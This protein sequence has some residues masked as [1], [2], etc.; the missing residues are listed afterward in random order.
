MELLQ[1]DF[2]AYGKH[3]TNLSGQDKDKTGWNE[4]LGRKEK[5]GMGR[6][7]IIGI[8]WEHNRTYC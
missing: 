1:N 6:D 2:G 3:G 7:G 8:R 5:K 4:V